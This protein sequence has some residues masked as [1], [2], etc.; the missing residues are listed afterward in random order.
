MI[1]VHAV[2]MKRAA[3]EAEA[4]RTCLARLVTLI[5]VC[6]GCGVGAY[7]RWFEQHSDPVACYSFCYYAYGDLCQTGVDFNAHPIIKKLLVRRV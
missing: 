3:S 7:L 1:A 5:R 6:A 2:S 4:V